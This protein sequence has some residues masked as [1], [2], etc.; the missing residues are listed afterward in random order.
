MIR[1]MGL[2]SLPAIGSLK[3]EETILEDTPM[4]AP[5][6]TPDGQPGTLDPQEGHV[7]RAE[8]MTLHDQA[9]ELYNMLSE[10]EQLEDFVQD[11]LSL[12]VNC[13]NTVYN[14]VKYEKNKTM[15]LGSGDGAPADASAG[16]VR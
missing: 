2:I 11:K 6:D 15:S 3:R 5:M 10:E 13:I 9:G 7:A 16:E 8:L 12:A 14:Y 1:L 4:E